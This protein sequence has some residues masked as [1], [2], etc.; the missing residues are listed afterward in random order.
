MHAE[1][2]TKQEPESDSPG[3]SASA[4]SPALTNGSKTSNGTSTTTANANGTTKP[5]FPPPKTDKPRPHVCQTCTRSFAR[6]EHLKRHERS[7]TKEK[8]FECPEC[9]RCFARRDLLLRHQQKL[10][11]TN[12]TTRPRTG[13]R[14]SVA[15]GNGN[16]RVRKNS[17]ANINV[18]GIN[19]AASNQIR[20]RANTISHIDLSSLGLM[21]GHAQLDR[22]N[23]LGLTM[24]GVGMMAG[25]PGLG[26]FDYRGMSTAMGQ[27]GNLHGLPKLDTAHANHMDMTHSLRTAP[28][29]ATFAGF[30]IDQLFTPHTTI[31]P[32]ALHFGSAGQISSTNIPFGVEAGTNQQVPIDDDFGWMRNWGMNIAGTDH[33]NAIEESSPSRMSSGDSPGDF[34]ESMTNS[35]AAIPIQNNNFQWHPQDLSLQQTLSHS[36]TGPFQLDGLCNGLPSLDQQNGTMSP[37]CLQDPTP[38]GEA[39]FHQAMMQHSNGTLRRHSSQA[40]AMQN[41]GATFFVSS[42]LSGG[43]G[44]RNATPEGVTLPSRADLQRY[45]EAFMQYAHPHLP[46]TH[47]ATVT[48]NPV[49]LVAPQK[50]S[51]SPASSSPYVTANGPQCLILGMAAIGALYEYDH[52]ASKNLFEAAKKMIS[53]YLEDRRKADMASAINREASHSTTPLWLVQAMLL[54]VIYGHHCGD[55]LAA[56]ISSNHIAALVSL[57]RSADLQTLDEPRSTTGGDTAMGNGDNGDLHA[58]WIKWKTAEEQRRCFFGIFILSS[59]L[60][61]AYNQTP[62]IMNS[63]ILLDLPCDE[64]L[65]EAPTAE[66]WHARGGL[67]RIEENSLTFAD[68]L[69]SL[70]T[71]NQRSSAFANGNFGASSSNLPASEIKPSTFGCLVLI[72]ALHNYIWETRSRHRGREWT[73]QETE[74]MIANIEPALNAWMAAWKA[75]ERHTLERPNPFGLGPLAADSIPLLDL[76]YVRLYVN[77]GR[78]AEAFWARDFNKMAE[79]LVSFNA[80]EDSP[81]NDANSPDARRQSASKSPDRRTLAQR[82]MSSAIPNDQAASTRRERHLRKAAAYAADALTVA[83]RFN[84]TYSDAHAH[85][86]PIQAAICF[87]DCAQVLAEWVTTVQERTGKYLGVLGRDAVD[88]TD[89]P[90]VMLLAPEDMEMLHKLEQIYTS[91]KDKHHHQEMSLLAMNPS[92]FNTNLHNNVNLDRCG[93]GSKIMRVTAMMLEKA[94]IWPITHVMAAALEIQATHMDRRSLQCTG[95]VTSTTT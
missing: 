24:N 34:S 15:G 87:L 37:S 85:E 47:I 52:P 4:A 83:C 43:T 79:E 23:A 12:T 72:N 42:P 82:R 31:N 28:P 26:H 74:S 80:F 55:R 13:R 29:Q 18:H 84:L 8:P 78:T 61:T 90:A 35:Q 45:I 22:M 89:V 69:S 53:L 30:D 36:S 11:M 60:T 56:E 9:T 41:Q 6:L 20:P 40:D 39:Y 92:T 70:L 54:N 67:A 75:N 48:F 95:E 64:E 94:V 58:T 59:L 14:E 50:G 77:L 86:L 68:A 66:E 7:H 62:S 1:D 65:Y 57:A 25:H 32:A 81:A 17:V 16:G 44:A 2:V 88:Y 51:P 76:A 5:A 63:E 73:M 49:D 71:A 21:D 93:Y 46:I 91:M 10:H 27:H 33:E 38:T 19:S 3:L